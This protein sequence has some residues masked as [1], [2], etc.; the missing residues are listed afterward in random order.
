MMYFQQTGKE[1]FI[2]MLSVKKVTKLH[3]PQIST[4]HTSKHRN[5]KMGK[6]ITLGMVDS[7]W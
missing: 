5:K 6:I 3:L 2:V 7:E 4:I 1:A